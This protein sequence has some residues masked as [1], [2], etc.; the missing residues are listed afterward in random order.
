MRQGEGAKKCGC[1]SVSI[2]YKVG[3]ILTDKVIFEERHEES[4]SLNLVNI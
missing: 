2:L 4:G 3:K 1:V